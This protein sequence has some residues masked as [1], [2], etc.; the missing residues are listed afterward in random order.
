M[1]APRPPR[2]DLV[3]VLPVCK[4]MLAFSRRPELKPIEKEIEVTLR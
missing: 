3:S 4:L 1:S 2:L